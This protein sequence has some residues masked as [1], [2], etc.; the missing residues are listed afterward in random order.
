VLSILLHVSQKRDCVKV[1]LKF[2]FT[3]L[4]L[5]FIFLV[6]VVNVLL[7]ESFWIRARY[8]LNFWLGHFGKL[9]N[10]QRI[11]W[12]V[13]FSLLLLIFACDFPLLLLDELL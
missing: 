12:I 4:C 2:E 6:L 9:F 5:H 11:L 3:I 13:F 7:L 10:F 1:F 8:F